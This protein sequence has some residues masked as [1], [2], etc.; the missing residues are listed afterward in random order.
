MYAMSLPFPSVRTSYG[1]WLIRFRIVICLHGALSL[2]VLKLKDVG[3]RNKINLSRNFSASI[4]R[5]VLILG[6]YTYAAR[7][8]FFENTKDKFP[9][10]IRIVASGSIT[11]FAHASWFIRLTCQGTTPDTVLR[12][13]AQGKLKFGKAMRFTEYDPIQVRE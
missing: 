3:S 1:S 11:T 13:E 8:S 5:S 10:H 4:A 6:S 12:S 7:G 9:N 2:G